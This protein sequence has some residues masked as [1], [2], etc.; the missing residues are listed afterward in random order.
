[1]TVISRLV[2]VSITFRRSVLFVRVVLATTFEVAVFTSTSVRAVALTVA[3]TLVCHISIAASLFTG[4]IGIRLLLD[5]LRVL[6]QG[7]GHR[8]A[9]LFLSAS[10]PA[11][12]PIRSRDCGGFA[13]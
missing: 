1:M 13:R 5:S 11:E 4:L 2:E 10:V 8:K 7:H 12:L 3:T 6:W 9:C